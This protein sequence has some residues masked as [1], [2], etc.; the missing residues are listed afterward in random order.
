MEVKFSII[1]KSEA[2]GVKILLNIRVDPQYI[3]LYCLEEFQFV[4]IIIICLQL[5]SSCC[6][7]NLL[8]LLQLV[9]SLNYFIL[10][11]FMLG[12]SRN[13]PT[14]CKR[15]YACHCVRRLSTIFI[16]NVHGFS[17]NRRVGQAG[18]G[19]NY[20]SM[21]FLSP[22][23]WHNLRIK[24]SRGLSILSTVSSDERRLQSELN[25]ISWKFPQRRLVW[26]RAEATSSRME[27][28]GATREWE[29]ER[30]RGVGWG[31]YIRPLTVSNCFTA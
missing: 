4:Y 11:N 1:H 13:C 17:K 29:R 26:P 8:A 7:F 14:H 2:E 9:F 31:L 30:V 21:L 28:K 22:H 18:R 3:N 27:I 24:M 10:L 19:G 20:I 25:Q 12:L 5:S 15:T 23:Y 16:L 6:H